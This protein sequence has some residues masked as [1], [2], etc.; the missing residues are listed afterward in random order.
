MEARTLKVGTS[1]ITEE[2][3][4][5]GKGPAGAGEGKPRLGSPFMDSCVSQAEYLLKIAKCLLK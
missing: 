2:A 3:D 5:L 4:L 1:S